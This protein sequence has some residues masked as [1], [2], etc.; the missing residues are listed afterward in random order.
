MARLYVIGPVTGKLDE[1]RA[2]FIKAADA[3]ADKGD[4]A[5]IPHM[6]VPEGSEWRDAMRISINEITDC[7]YRY[8]GVA[9]LDGWEQSKG[10][11]LERVVAQACGIPCKTGD[12]WLKEAS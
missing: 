11:C 12:E 3:L 1:N 9:L 4:L 7:R 2:A 10:A 8:D 5:Y 6:F